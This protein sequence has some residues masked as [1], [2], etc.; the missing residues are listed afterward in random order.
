MKK[1]KKKKKKVELIVED[2]IDRNQ[3][4]VVI[5]NTVEDPIEG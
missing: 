1:S 4:M 5:E 3:E 2:S